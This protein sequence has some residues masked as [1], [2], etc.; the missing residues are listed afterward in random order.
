MM[1]EYTIC[2]GSGNRFVMVDAVRDGAFLRDADLPALARSACRLGG[3]LDG[4][5]LAVA[6]GDQYG[7]RM[8]NPDGSE[9]EMCG[10]GIRCVARLVAERYLSD[11]HFALW[12]GGRR[13][14]ISREMAIAGTIPTYG[15]LI[16]VRLASPDFRVEDAAAGFVGRCI[17]QLDSAVAFTYLNLGNPHL[18]ACV[19]QIDMEQLE[20]L[21]RHVTEL[22][23][24]FPNGINVSLFR[25][26]GRNGI[27]VATYERGVGITFS[28]GTA[29]TACSVAA[30]LLGSCDFGARIA[31]RNRGG[32]VRCRCISDGAGLRAELVGNATYEAVGQARVTPSC[33]E[34][35]AE[36][37]VTPFPAEQAEYEAF[38]RALTEN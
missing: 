17:P 2:H 3:G 5:L 4:L 6:C 8:F 20:V 30:C 16:P 37:S 21:G 29:M 24:L 11:D 33:G 18:A 26:M 14:E 1:C 31:V 28:C 36:G 34:F 27:Y 32:E 35:V 12:S 22:K 23:E 15:V 7:M 9:A 13:Y 19:E 38:L 25:P 10:N